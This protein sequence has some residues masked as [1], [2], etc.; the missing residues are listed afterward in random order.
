MDSKKE[1]S[2][3]TMLQ[4]KNRRAVDR[5]ADF[6]HRKVPSLRTLPQA[7]HTNQ[8][9]PVFAI[10]KKRKKFNNDI[11]ADGISRKYKGIRRCAPEQL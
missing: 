9:Q 11:L 8:T 4:T 1:T 5:M 7:A 3:A 6:S 2:S 10:D